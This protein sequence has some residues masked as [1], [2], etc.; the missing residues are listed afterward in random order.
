MSSNNGGNDGRGP[1]T[2]CDPHD[3]SRTPNF[4]RFKRNFMTGSSAHFLHEDDYSLWQA[5]QDTDQGGNA[6]GADAMPGAQQAGHL[7]AVR[8][9]KKRQA[10]VALLALAVV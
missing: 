7:N 2:Y 5:C 9:R 1:R 3:G 8:R 6:A 4:L 10:H